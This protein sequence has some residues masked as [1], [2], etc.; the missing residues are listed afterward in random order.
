MM[1]KVL[2]L[3]TA[4][5]MAVS[6][7][8]V[9]PVMT[10]MAETSGNY[11]YTVLYDGT[12]EITGYTGS[13]TEIEIPSEINGKAVT[14]IYGDVYGAFYDCDSLTKVTIP[15]SVK[16]IGMCAFRFCDSLKTI[17][18]GNSVTIIGNMAFDSCTSLTSITIPNSVIN[19][20]KSAFEYCSSLTNITIPDSVTNIV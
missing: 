3:L 6:L 2:N 10:A 8:G 11:E 4:L 14:S 1:K 5:V 7:V 19:I 15:N 18:I 20:G 17:I 16:S 9:L 13:E 12:V